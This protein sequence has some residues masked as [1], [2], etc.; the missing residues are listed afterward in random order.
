MPKELPAVRLT[1]VSAEGSPPMVVAAPISSSSSEIPMDGSTVGIG[2]KADGSPSRI[3]LGSL[4]D[5]NTNASDPG[6]GI[7]ASYLQDTGNPPTEPP[8]HAP[9]GLRQSSPALPRLSRAFSM[10]LASQLGH[11]RHP[12][13]P[14]SPVARATRSPYDEMSTELADSAQMVIQTILQLSPPQL[15]DPAKE[16]FSACS[17]QIPTSSITALLTSMKNLNYMSANIPTFSPSGSPTPSTPEDESVPSVEKDNFDVG[18]MLQ[19]VGDALGGLAAQ[20]GVELVLFHGD[21]GMKHVCIRGDEC[22]MLYA[23]SHVRLS[24]VS[25]RSSSH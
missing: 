23:L 11:L 15:L 12:H 24:P 8:A 18:E 19:S 10:P 14:L 6:I 4:P 20:A 13:T 3:D 22:A 2:T 25:P 16:Q 21:V 9:D 7:A 5:P 17:L 1:D